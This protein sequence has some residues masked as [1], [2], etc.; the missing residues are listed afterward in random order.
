MFAVGLTL[1]FVLSLFGP[2]AVGIV[3]AALSVLKG[4]LPTI[5]AGA[6]D[7]FRPRDTN[8]STPESLRPPCS[9]RS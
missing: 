2:M 6:T 8:E 4:D 7:R 3:L 1:I 5:P 9:M